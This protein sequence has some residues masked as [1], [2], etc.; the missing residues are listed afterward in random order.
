MPQYPLATSYFGVEHAVVLEHTLAHAALTIPGISSGPVEVAVVLQPRA[1]MG[2]WRIVSDFGTLGILTADEA[3]D[4]PALDTLR[5]AHFDPTTIATVEIVDSELEIAVMLGLNP[6]MLP[7][8]S[9]PAGAALINGGFGATVDLSSG[10]SPSLAEPAAW[11]VSISQLD[12]ALVAST[13]NHVL[14]SFG[15]AE[16]LPHIATICNTAARQC[17]SLCARAYTAD[18]RLAVDLPLPDSQVPFAPAIPPLPQPD[19]SEPQEQSSDW[20]VDFD[21]TD[22]SEAMPSGKRTV[23]SPSNLQPAPTA[24]AVPTS[25]PEPAVEIPTEEPESDF[26]SQ[27]AQMYWQDWPTARKER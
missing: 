6:W 14:G 16:S 8:N 7:Q 12:D 18:G 25:A 17:A 22:F 24:A 4:F 13:D 5:S 23:T 27:D 2:G 1:Q 15:T 26:S 21:D 20:A 10:D 9:Q 19:K 11:I 3:A